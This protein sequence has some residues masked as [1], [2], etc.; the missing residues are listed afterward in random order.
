VG[1]GAASVGGQ[2]ASDELVEC[3]FEKLTRFCQN[4]R[5]DICQMQEA[6]LPVLAC[7]HLSDMLRHMFA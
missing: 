7:T 1:Q 5:A 6:N 4:M 3:F 2:C